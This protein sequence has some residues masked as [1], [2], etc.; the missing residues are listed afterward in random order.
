[1]MRDSIENDI[2]LAKTRCDMLESAV[3]D[4]YV[5]ATPGTIESANRLLVGWRG[6]LRV[7]C[8]EQDRISR[9]VKLIE[10]EE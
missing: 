8:A 6:L 5:A 3:V 10:A 4:E 1:M 2:K 9:T 7:L